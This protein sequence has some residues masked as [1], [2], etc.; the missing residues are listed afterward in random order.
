M[1]HRRLRSMRMWQSM[2]RPGLQELWL[3]QEFPRPSWH[4]TH[5]PGHQIA[6][7][8]FQYTLLQAPRSPDSLA[9]PT[10]V[11]SARES[12]PTPRAAS[13]RERGTSRVR[14]ALLNSLGYRRRAQ[15]P[16]SAC[17]FLKGE[18]NLER[19]S[20]LHTDRIWVIVGHLSTYIYIYICMY[21][22][23]CVHIIISMYY[24][25]YHIPYGSF[26]EWGLRLGGPDMRDPTVGLY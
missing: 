3:S 23:I 14:Q 26:D 10:P 16:R 8:S 25:R 22:Y 17:W 1:A 9:C 24:S 13:P 21:I 6:M 19:V 2:G 15:T 5:T 4:Q 18:M 11:S 7:A 12:D 20:G